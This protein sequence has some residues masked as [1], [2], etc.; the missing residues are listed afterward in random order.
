M[1]T[2][3]QGQGTLKQSPRGRFAL[4]RLFASWMGSYSVDQSGPKLKILPSQVPWVL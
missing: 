3:V 2:D 1:K 4:A